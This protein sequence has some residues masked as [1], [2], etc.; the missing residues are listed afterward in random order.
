ME[1]YRYAIV[2]I[3]LSII[4]IMIL[5][6]ADIGVHAKNGKNVDHKWKQNLRIFT[7]LKAVAKTKSTPIFWTVPL[8]SYPNLAR[9]RLFLIDHMVGCSSYMTPEFPAWNSIG[10]LRPR[11]IKSLT[12]DRIGTSGG[13]AVGR[14]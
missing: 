13:V 7:G 4:A 12:L 10:M 8:C 2:A 3:I 14:R 1:M 11:S 9:K 6:M 5:N